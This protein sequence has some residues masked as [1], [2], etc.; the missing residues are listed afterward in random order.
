MRYSF[1]CVVLETYSRLLFEKSGL[2]DYRFLFS[3]SITN[4]VVDADE[5]FRRRRL[6]LANKR[7]FKLCSHAKLSAADFVF[8]ANFN[9]TLVALGREC[10]L[11][12]KLRCFNNH[13][14]KLTRSVIAGILK[15]ASFV[16]SLGCG[17]G[18]LSLSLQS[19]IVCYE[20]SLAVAKVCVHNV[21]AAAPSGAVSL[22]SG[23]FES[24]FIGK[25]LPNAVC[26]ECG[27]KKL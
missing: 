13:S 5:Q 8:F 25:V 16:L 15:G 6:C 20:R 10:V 27:V 19:D 18:V 24:A 23:A 11:D 7:V 1:Y 26:F 22:E 14:K 9:H 2:P 21:A 3:V 12:C 4:L 17:C